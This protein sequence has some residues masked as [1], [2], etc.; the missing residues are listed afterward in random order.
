MLFFS[1]KRILGSERLQFSSK[2]LLKQIL[3]FFSIVDVHKNHPS[4]SKSV[5]VVICINK[6]FLLSNFQRIYK[7]INQTFARLLRHKL[8]FIL[9]HLINERKSRYANN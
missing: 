5:R 9:L 4:F 7:T 1:Y 6:G 3:E 2:A 8:K